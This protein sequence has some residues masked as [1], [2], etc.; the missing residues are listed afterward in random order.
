MTQQ[1][2]LHASA[3]THFDEQREGAQRVIA[4]ADLAGIKLPE[5]PADFEDDYLALGGQINNNDF[6]RFS[7]PRG[8]LADEMKRSCADGSLPK[9]PDTLPIGNDVLRD[10]VELAKIANTLKTRDPADLPQ[11][12]CSRCPAAIWTLSNEGLKS[13]CRIFYTTP[14]A[15]GCAAPVSRCD[16]F[17]MAI[18]RAAEPV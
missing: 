6:V 13:H 1:N 5:L 3:K 8:I 2:A 4:A 18:K 14:W 9:Y 11:T 12:I 7:T 16:G 10:L 17:F 15:P